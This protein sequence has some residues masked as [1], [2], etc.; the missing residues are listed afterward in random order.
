MKE[1]NRPVWIVRDCGIHFNDIKDWD[2]EIKTLTTEISEEEKKSWYAKYYYR[3]IKMP[4]HEN[5]KACEINNPLPRELALRPEEYLSVMNSPKIND[6][7]SGYYVFEDGISFSMTH[8]VMEGVTDEKL[9]YFNEHFI[10]EGDLYYKCW[11]PGMHMKHYIQ[12]CVE[13]VGLGMELVNFLAGY[14][15]D[16]LAG[17]K[18]YKVNDP[19]FIAFGGGG[20]V[21]WPLHDLFNHPRYALQANWWRDLPDGSGRE[22]FM[23]FWQGLT[24]KD[25]KVVRAIP[26]GERIEMEYA[27]SHM[28]HSIWEY[29]QNAKLVNDFWEDHLKGLC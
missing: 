10:P 3:E 1:N 26:E 27:R 14:S 6:L 4:T 23:V 12:G 17:V 13:D 7:R 21:S 5:L 11:Y 25:G 24:W 20:G 16:E 9:N 15:L 18:D 22:N 28:N 2:A 29:T 8:I 19:L